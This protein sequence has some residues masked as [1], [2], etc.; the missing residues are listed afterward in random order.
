[1]EGGL[2]AGNK[3]L[4]LVYKRQ[5]ARPRV[6]RSCKVIEIFAISDFF[7]QWS[8]TAGLFIVGAIREKFQ[9]RDFSSSQG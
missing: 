5:K 7:Q 6:H 4:A 9:E 8:G 2:V 1:M 3:Q